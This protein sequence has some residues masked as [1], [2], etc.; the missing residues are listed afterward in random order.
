[1]KNPKYEAKSNDKPQIKKSEGGLSAISF[2][3]WA[4]QKKEY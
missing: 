3:L 4:I 2:E 1:M